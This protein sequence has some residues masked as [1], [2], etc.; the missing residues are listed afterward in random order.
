MAAAPDNDDFFQQPADAGTVDATHSEVA[1]APPRLG[2]LAELSVEEFD[3]VARSAQLTFV[4]PGG[5]ICSQGDQADRFFIVVDGT[6]EV[7]R[8]GE[9]LATL[10]DGAFFGESALLVGG[11]RSATVRALTPCSIWSIDYA[12]FDAAVAHH[13]LA[14]DEHGPEAARRIDATPPTAFDE[15]T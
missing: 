14:D 1:T 9:L 4:V 5:T 6:V 10:A 8:D 11:R 15:P 3:S 13:L 12:A 2:V 7:E